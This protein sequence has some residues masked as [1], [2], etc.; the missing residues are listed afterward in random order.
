MIPGRLRRGIGGLGLL[1]RLT[2]PLTGVKQRLVLVLLAQSLHESGEERL[3]G[4][5]R[6]VHLEDGRTPLLAHPT[7]LCDV[8]D[9]RVRSQFHGGSSVI[10]S[11]LF[12]PAETGRRLVT[13]CAG[14]P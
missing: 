14:R 3:G 7:P 5:M 12:P 2:Q 11:A 6:R 13:R 10:T 1:R 4:G 8:D 9:V